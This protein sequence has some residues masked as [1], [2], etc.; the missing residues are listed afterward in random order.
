MRID[1]S[2][3]LTAVTYL[4]A[5]GLVLAETFFNYEIDQKVFEFVIYIVG[6]TTAAGVIN[7]TRKHYLYLK[8]QKQK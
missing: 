5:I 3:S 4:L 7:S 8:E 2:F 1:K 6:S